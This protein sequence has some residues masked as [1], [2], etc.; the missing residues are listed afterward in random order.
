MPPRCAPRRTGSARSPPR[1]RGGLRRRPPPPGLALGD[2]PARFAGAI[3]SGAFV[4]RDPDAPDTAPGRRWDPRRLVVGRL[5]VERAAALALC[6]GIAFCA[7]YVV[8]ANHWYWVPLTVVIVMKPDLGSIFARAVL[9]AGGTAIGVAIGAVILF[10]L[11]KGWPLLGGMLI[12]AA[13]LP[14]AK[15]V[16]YAA[17]AV[18]LTPLILILLDLV[19]PTP[20]TVD[21]GAQRLADTVIG[22]AIVLVFGYFIWPRRHGREL[23]ARFGAAM[24]AIA[25]YLGAAAGPEG[26]GAM[27]ARWTAYASLS[28]LRA[29]LGRSLSEPPPAGR[30]AA[31]WFPLVAAAERVC[32]LIT[33]R[34]AAAPPPPPAEVAAVAAQLRAV[35]EGGAPAGPAPDDGFLAAVSQQAARISARLETAAAERR[36]PAA[37]G[38]PGAAA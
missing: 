5:V 21:Y 13:V 20:H 4:T 31:A 24:R 10:L 36:A 11:P 23:A 18:V 7:R 26:Q 25:D 38:A 16:S 19:V 2:A 33:A 12:L 37:P 14:W 6:V 34:P 32:D 28:D 9:R 22:G 30:E 15:S 35:A 27:A 1:C 8:Q 29:T 17:Q 3:A